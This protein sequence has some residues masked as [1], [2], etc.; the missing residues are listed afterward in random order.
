ME[1]NKTSEKIIKNIRESYKPK[2]KL[3][4]EANTPDIV[5]TACYNNLDVWL[6]RKDAMDFFE[7]CMYGSEGSER[8]R[9]VNVYFDLK[10]GYDLATDGDSDEVWEIAWMGNKVSTA[11]A[12]QKI[13]PTPAKNVVAK[14]KG[15][16][17]MPPKEF[18]DVLGGLKESKEKF[19]KQDKTKKKPKNIKEAKETKKQFEVF[20]E[21][22]VSEEFTVEAVDMDEAAEIMMDKYNKGEVVL[23]P[24]NLVTKSIM[25]RDPDTE[26]ETGWNE[27]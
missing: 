22:V 9:Y 15:G 20:I 4:E 3:K 1:R 16:K 24:G 2:K 17:I 5:F 25:V 12:K 21:E 8:E 19:M 14:I 23:E 7:E 27:F 6:S 13:E 11:L 10:A 18:L 26:E